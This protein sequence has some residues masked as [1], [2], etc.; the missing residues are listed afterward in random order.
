MEIDVFIADF[1]SLFEET[2]PALITPESQF[3]T[4]TE[5]GSIKAMSIMAMVDQK[6]KVQVNGNDLRKC[7][8]IKELFEIVKSKK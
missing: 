5:W 3:R 7:T 2:D 1:S 6:Y 4:L 8:T